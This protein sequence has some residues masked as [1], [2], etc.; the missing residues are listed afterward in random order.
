ME[1][2]FCA[3]F[4]YQIYIFSDSSKNTRPS[5]S[6]AEGEV[7]VVQKFTK[8]EA[9]I[10]NPPPRP[11]KPQQVNVMPCYL[12]LTPT[13]SGYVIYLANMIVCIGILPKK[14]S[15]KINIYYT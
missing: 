10:V 1:F 12:N 15:Y 14:L 13:K 8:T 9:N 3:V 7:V 2:N 5:D 4:F 6:S 11:P